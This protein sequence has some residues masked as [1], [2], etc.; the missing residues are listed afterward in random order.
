MVPA[1]VVCRKEWVSFA[2]VEVPDSLSSSLLCLAD[3][4]VLYRGWHMWLKLNGSMRQKI[5]LD[6]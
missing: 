5:E 6:R 1:E 4:Y 3:V 2:V